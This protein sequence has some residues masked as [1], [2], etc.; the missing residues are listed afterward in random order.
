MA[1][2]SAGAKQHAGQSRLD[3]ASTNLDI[4]QDLMPKLVARAPDAV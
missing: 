4:L 2:S 1:G 3:L